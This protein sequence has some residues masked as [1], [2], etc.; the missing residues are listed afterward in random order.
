MLHLGV[1]ICTKLKVKISVYFVTNIFSFILNIILTKPKHK[2]ENRKIDF[3][4]FY[5]R[6]IKGVGQSSEIYKCYNPSF[7]LKIVHNATLKHFFSV[8]TI[9]T[10]WQFMII[11]LV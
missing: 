2:T 1:I 11:L 5:L 8:V 4:A 3:D 10:F 7:A 9:C 6:E